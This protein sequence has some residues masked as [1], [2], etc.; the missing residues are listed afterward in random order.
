V[1]N[2]RRPGLDRP[3]VVCPV[4]A[5]GQ[6]Q[7]REEWVGLAQVP[8]QLEAV[9]VGEREVYD[10]QVGLAASH[11]PARL[12]ERPGLCHHLEIALLVEHERERLPERGVILDE[13]KTLHILPSAALILR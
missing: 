12:T 7:R 5:R 8:D 13:H 9:A 4:E 10:P 2:T 1:Q 3:G 6:N 11:H